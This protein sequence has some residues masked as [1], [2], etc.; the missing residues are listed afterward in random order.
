MI[1]TNWSTPKTNIFAAI[2]MLRTALAAGCNA[3]LQRLWN[4]E[5]DH[6]IKI[7]N[8]DRDFRNYEFRIG[9]AASIKTITD[10]Q[11]MSDFEKELSLNYVNR[12]GTPEAVKRYYETRE[13]SPD[14]DLGIGVSHLVHIEDYLEHLKTT[15]QYDRERLY[16]RQYYP[17]YGDETQ[18]FFDFYRYKHG[19]QWSAKTFKKKVWVVELLKANEP[20]AKIPVVLSIINTVLAPLY[21]IMKY[22]PRKQVLHMSKYRCVT[23]RVGDVTNGLSVEFHVPKKFGFK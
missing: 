14:N 20:E 18:H 6:P 21:F 4:H 2:L 13:L 12:Y 1:N 7:R 19:S 15:N 17:A 9:Y 23:F 5:C 8:D 11:T 3:R 22:I 16:R 10:D